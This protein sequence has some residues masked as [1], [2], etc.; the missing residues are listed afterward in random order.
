MFF[1]FLRF[2]PDASKDLKLYKELFLQIL[3]SSVFGIGYLSKDG[4]SKI[5]YEWGQIGYS[6]LVRSNSQKQR[7]FFLMGGRSSYAHLFLNFLKNENN[8]AYFYDLN[9]K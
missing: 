9:A 6:Y 2:N 4:N 5:S 8:A 1:G 7:F 3:E